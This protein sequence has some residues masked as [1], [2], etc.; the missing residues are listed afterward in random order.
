MRGF[1][2]FQVAHA[3]W[4][5]IAIG[6]RTVTVTTNNDKTGY[7]LAADQAVN[8]T[9]WAGTTVDA[10]ILVDGKQA[11][12]GD[13]RGWRG[14]VP[15]ALIAGRVD[16]HAQVVGDKTGYSLTA[17]SYAIRASSTQRS[18]ILVSGA[19]SATAAI[20]SVTT[21]RAVL[22]FLGCTSTTAS[23]ANDRMHSRVDLTNATTV[24]AT[25]GTTNDDSTAGF[26]LAEF[27]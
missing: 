25:K 2:P 8:T 19:A 23:V 20:S 24:T 26:D 15:N 21:T 10:Q 13:T 6:S 14:V 9:K 16:A 1:S 11:I 27:F 18:T 3:V 12:A 7:S 17:G 5:L 4:N 22:Q